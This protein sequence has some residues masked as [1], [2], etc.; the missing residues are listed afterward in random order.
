MDEIMK[1]EAATDRHA[2][3]HNVAVNV[4][5]PEHFRRLA[6]LKIIPKSIMALLEGQ[7]DRF[8][9]YDKL[10][11]KIEESCFSAHP[12][13][14]PMLFGLNP[15]E[16][17]QDDQEDIPAYYW[18]DEQETFTLFTSKPKG[19]GKGKKGKGNGQGQSIRNNR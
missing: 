10:K 16:E 3:R 2:G 8:E 11:N 13:S 7:L 15:A 4:F 18:D 12:G 9:T 6:L 1:F 5:F 19:K 17:Q 14:A